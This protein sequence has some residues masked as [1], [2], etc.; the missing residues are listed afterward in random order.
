MR[1]HIVWIDASNA[2]AFCIA[3]AVVQLANFH[4]SNF[5][6]TTI[7]MLQTVSSS[8]M[9]A[10]RLMDDR[11]ERLNLTLVSAAELLARLIPR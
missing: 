10:M 1:R 3:D 7:T 6:V 4:T 2:N 5:L 9:A 8:V 11:R